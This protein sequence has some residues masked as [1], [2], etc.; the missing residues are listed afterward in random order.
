MLVSS[1]I[2]AGLAAGTTCCP[3]DPRRAH[4]MGSSILIAHTVLG[5]DFET[6]LPVFSVFTFTMFV[7]SDI[8]WNVGLIYQ[9]EKEG[10]MDSII[11][12]N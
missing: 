7:G 1:F 2:R 10:G 12:G 6:H 5:L 9:L 8:K 4:G 3:L 11:L